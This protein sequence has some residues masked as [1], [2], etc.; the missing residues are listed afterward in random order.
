MQ[1]NH[2]IATQIVKQH[3]DTL[4]GLEQLTDRRERTRCKK[5]QP[6]KQG[7]GTRLLS[8][9]ART[10]NRLSSQWSFAELQALISYKAALSGSLAIKVDADYTSKQCPRCGHAA[11]ANRPS[12]G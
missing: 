10:A 9:K 8:K 2:Q 6:K 1:A 12:K 4:I 7:K 5:H 3:P 11:D